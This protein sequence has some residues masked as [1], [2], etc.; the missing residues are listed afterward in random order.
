MLILDP[1][2]A[3][4]NKLFKIVIYSQGHNH[5]H[6]E[7]AYDN[8]ICLIMMPASTTYRFQMIDVVIGKVFKDGMCEAWANWMLTECEK[9][10]LSK[11]ANFKA[12]TRLDSCQWVK[13]VW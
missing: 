9:R 4:V 7:W 3:H 1:A 11:T 13:T 2:A 10:G 5:T 12:P 6:V 8:R